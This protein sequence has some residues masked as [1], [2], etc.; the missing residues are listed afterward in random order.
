[1]G[2]AP[3][4]QARVQERACFLKQVLVLDVFGYELASGL[5]PDELCDSGGVSA[6]L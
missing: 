5:R 6:L 3:G 1:M 2:P 4:M